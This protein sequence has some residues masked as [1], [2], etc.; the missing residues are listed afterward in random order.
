M[1]DARLYKRT[2]DT[3]LGNV[4]V[5]T[6]KK[7]KNRRQRYD[8]TLM[9]TYVYAMGCG[10]YGLELAVLCYLLSNAKNLSRCSYTGRG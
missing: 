8:V 7:E 2:I 5:R 10:F 4:V 3:V 9:E 6:G 1:K